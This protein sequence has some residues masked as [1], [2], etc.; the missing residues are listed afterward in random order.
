MLASRENHARMVEKESKKPTQQLEDVSL[1]EGDA[2]KVTKVGAGLD[3][4]LKGKIMEFLKQNADI[5]A[6]THK[7]MPGIDN[8]VIEH[9]LNVNPT[10]KQ[11]QQ[12][13]RVFAHK[14]NKAVVEEVE[15]LLTAGFIREVYYPEWLANVVMVKK[16][17]VKWRMCVDFTDLNRA[18]P[19]DSFPLP[20]IDQLVDSTTD[21]KLLTFIDAFSSYNQIRMNKE[22]QEKTTFVTSQGQYYYRVMPFGLKNARATY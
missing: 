10:R 1:I 13:Q 2:T 19:K 12:K 16:S 22:V 3:S 4:H 20:M 6:W 21:H 17:N 11:V 15:K 9:R 8:K 18:C 14:R 7:D 5:F